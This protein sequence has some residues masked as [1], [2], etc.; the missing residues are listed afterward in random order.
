MVA[1]PLRGAD[2]GGHNREQ[3]GEYESTTRTPGKARGYSYEIGSRHTSTARRTLRVS[4]R[5][6]GGSGSRGSSLSRSNARPKRVLVAER[7]RSERISGACIGDRRVGAQGIRAGIFG[8]YVLRTRAAGANRARAGQ[9][10]VRDTSGQNRCRCV[11]TSTTYPLPPERRSS[12]P[13][14]GYPFTL[15]LISSSAMLFSV[16]LSGSARGCLVRR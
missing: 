7:G 4:G 6:L 9:G 8:T 1:A 2:V 5:K 10:E 12:L 11:P 3:R 16:S 15:S 14:S 13:P